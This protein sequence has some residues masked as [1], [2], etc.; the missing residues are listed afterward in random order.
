[1]TPT[2]LENLAAAMEAKAAERDATAE[3]FTKFYLYSMA[4][5]KTKEADAYRDCAAMLRAALAVKPATC[6]H[7]GAPV[8]DAG[9]RCGC[10]KCGYG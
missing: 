7:S 3:N 5:H 1:M 9:G 8:T 10:F 6:P 4:N 2:D